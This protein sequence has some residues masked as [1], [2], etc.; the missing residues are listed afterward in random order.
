MPRMRGP[1]VRMHI[2]IARRYGKPQV[3]K[4]VI[5]TEDMRWSYDVRGTHPEYSAPMV[6]ARVD[7]VMD[8]AIV[9]TLAGGGKGRNALRDNM[10]VGGGRRPAAAGRK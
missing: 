3:G 10:R 2:P 8:R 6:P 7:H 9:D 1:I 5:E 4:L